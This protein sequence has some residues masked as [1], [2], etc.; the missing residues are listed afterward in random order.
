MAVIKYPETTITVGTDSYT[1]P[2]TRR[3]KKF[4]NY[5]KVKVT[6]DVSGQTPPHC[7]STLAFRHYGTTESWFLIDDINP[8]I[9]EC[10]IE[11]GF[12]VNVA[13]LDDQQNLSI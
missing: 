5:D 3:R 1:I 13:P 7:Y 9:H 2:Y 11:D 10:D 8:L 6:S 4:K 12:E